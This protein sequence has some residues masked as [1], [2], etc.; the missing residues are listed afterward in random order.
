MWYE[1]VKQWDQ[2]WQDWLEQ[3]VEPS[4]KLIKIIGIWQGLSSTSL[5]DSKSVMLSSMIWKQDKEY[6]TM[7]RMNGHV[8]RKV[9]VIQTRI[10]EGKS[11]CTG[12]QINKYRQAWE[13]LAK[14][15]PVFV[16]HFMLT[17]IEIEAYG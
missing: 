17:Y 1:R 15:Q 3:G 2:H 11:W 10:K 13:F 9:M 6:S 16:L 4:T 12:T 8:R 5:K 7:V 14:S